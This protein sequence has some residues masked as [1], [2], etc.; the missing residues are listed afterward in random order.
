MANYANADMVGH[1]GR[2][3]ATIQA[4]EFLDS[5]LGRVAEACESAGWAV[6]ITADHGNA[7]QMIDPATGAAH[8]AHTTNPVPL[9]ARAPGCQASLRSGR[10]SDVVPTLIDYLGDSPPEEMTGRSLWQ[11]S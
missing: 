3:D 7:E 5:C 4:V 8:T 2:F 11:G 10:L 6:F 1:T 9:L